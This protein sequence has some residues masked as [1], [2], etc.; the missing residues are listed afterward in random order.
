LFC[1]PS[2]F[3]L[4]N[5]DQVFMVIGRSENLNK[6]YLHTFFL[7]FSPPPLALTVMV[8]AWLND[9]STEGKEGIKTKSNGTW[10]P[11][12]PRDGRRVLRVCRWIIPDRIINT[13][14]PSAPTLPTNERS[15]RDTKCLLH[16]LG[17]FHPYARGWLSRIP[18]KRVSVG[19]V[20][21]PFPPVDVGDVTVEN[22]TRSIILEC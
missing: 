14:P 8:A 4:V 17:L 15:G 16:L 11:V 5:I 13:W 19:C 12:R 2:L 7:L 10:R 6:N 18:F 20:F 22:D 3:R 9:L 21:F 1:L